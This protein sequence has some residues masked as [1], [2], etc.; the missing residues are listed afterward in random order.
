MA[1]DAG[2]VGRTFPAT[3]PYE[4]SRAKIDEFVAAIGDDAPSAAPPTF[5]TVVTFQAMQAF[6]ADP[7]VGIELHRIVHGDQRFVH[8]RPLRPGDVV[9]T[10]LTVES[11]RAMGGADI[12]GT[13]SEIVD[14]SGEPV[15]T[16]YATLF[17]RGEDTGT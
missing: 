14:A 9:T 2:L 1:V 6:L 5:P 10:R 4:V 7:G 11:I 15:C 13:R 8:L 3:A 17:H 12:I 16:A